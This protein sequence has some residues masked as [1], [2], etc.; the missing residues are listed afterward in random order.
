MEGHHRFKD[1]CINYLLANRSA[2]TVNAGVPPFS[3]EQCVDLLFYVLPEIGDSKD[4]GQFRAKVNV[5]LANA[6]YAFL[7]SLGK[8]VKPDAV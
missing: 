6:L 1:D 8:A 3:R 2:T 4:L 7:E 5:R